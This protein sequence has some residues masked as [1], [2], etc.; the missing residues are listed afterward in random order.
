MRLYSGYQ[1]RLL[2]GHRLALRLEE[3]LEVCDGEL[4][5]GLQGVVPP[6][7]HLH[8]ARKILA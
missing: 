3:R 8:S 4:V 1:I 2:A 6:H 7:I 5:Q